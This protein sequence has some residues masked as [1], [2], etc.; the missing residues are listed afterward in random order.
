M[1]NSEEYQAAIKVRAGAA[2]A[3]FIVMEGVE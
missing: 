1:Y 3:S 2:E